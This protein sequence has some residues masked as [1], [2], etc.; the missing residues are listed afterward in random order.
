MGSPTSA[1]RNSEDPDYRYSLANE[2][3]FLAWIRTALALMAAAVAMVQLVPPFVLPG[4]R[5]ALGVVLTL[6]GLLLAVRAYPR[7]AGNERSMRQRESLP[8]TSLFLVVSLALGAV[9]VVVLV[10][11]VMGGE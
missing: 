9:A 7:W 6:L 11:I 1:E 4:G 10:L 2:R 5:T 3:T 8:R